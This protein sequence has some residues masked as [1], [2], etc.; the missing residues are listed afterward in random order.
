[1]RVLMPKRPRKRG[2]KGPFRAY[3]FHIALRLTYLETE[4]LNRALSDPGYALT[5]YEAAALGR[6]RKKVRLAAEA[7]QKEVQKRSAQKR[8]EKLRWKLET[9][10]NSGKEVSRWELAELEYWEC[11]ARGD[12]DYEPGTIKLA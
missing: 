8:A 6:V 4:A 7:D 3:N 9:R 1:M 11:R 10:K 12:D 5:H 2:D